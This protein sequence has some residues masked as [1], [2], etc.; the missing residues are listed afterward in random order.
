MD[1]YRSPGW[2]ASGIGCMVLLVM[3][4]TGCGANTPTTGTGTTPGTTATAPT[5]NC[6]DQA[7]GTVQSISGTTFVMNNIQ[8]KSIHISYTSTT[9]FTRQTTGTTAAL[10]EGKQAQVRV[11]QN[12][13]GSYSAQQILITNGLPGGTFQGRRQGT[14]TGP[15]FCARGANGSG[16]NRRNGTPRAIGGTPG[17]NQTNRAI[18]GTIGLLN[19]KTL[20]VTD[21]S[22][23]DYAVNLVSSTQIVIVAQVNAG[24]LQA[25]VPISVTGIRPRQGEI[26]AQQ[27]VILQRL[28]TV[29]T[30]R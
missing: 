16:V 9:T 21:R 11:M 24:A 29:N 27:V 20:T 12:S 23:N 19:G 10:Q 7:T 30:G 8:G 18:S 4:I 3:L 14:T 25:G 26:T 22:N 15:A 2:I 6:I 17:A 28:P 1:S 13:D 5:T